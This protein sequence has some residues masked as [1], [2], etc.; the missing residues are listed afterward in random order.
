MSAEDLRLTAK[1]FETPDGVTEMP[2]GKV[3]SVDFGPF[4]VLKLEFEPGWRWSEHAKAEAK[5]DWCEYPHL[6]YVLSGH[7]HVRMKD[8]TELEYGPGDLVLIPPGHDGWTIG[9]EPAVMLDF[10]PLLTAA[11]VIP[12]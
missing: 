7:H 3:K 5:T 10:G 4:H 2:K 8:G 6:L 12:E 1:N 11:T 9:D